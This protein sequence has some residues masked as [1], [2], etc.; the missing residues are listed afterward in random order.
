V[1]AHEDNTLVRKALEEPGA[2]RVLVVDGGGSMRC[3]MLGG[4]LAEMAQN[5][6]WAGVVV[7][8]C[9]RDCRDLARAAVG[10][11][12]LAAHPMKSAKRGEGQRDVPV[13]FG[14]VT[15]RPGEHLT[16]DEDG[17]VITETA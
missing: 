9:V 13:T 10:I 12:A 3:A 17:I 15:F 7:Y 11:K 4:N 14:G 2:G 6:G 8:G 16:A 5:N 1:K